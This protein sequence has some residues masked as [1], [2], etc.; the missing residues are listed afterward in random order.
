MPAVSIF[1]ITESV[2]GSPSVWQVIVNVDS[3]SMV[4]VKGEFLVKLLLLFAF[5]LAIYGGL[6]GSETVHDLTL[7]ALQEMDDVPPFTTRVGFAE[8]FTLELPRLLWPSWLFWFS[9]LFTLLSTLS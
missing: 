8:I 4:A 6:D 7:L 9:W 3:P 1:T 2:S 5:P